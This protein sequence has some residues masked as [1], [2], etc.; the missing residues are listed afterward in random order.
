M[1]FVT[2]LTI[3]YRVVSAKKQLTIYRFINDIFPLAV[4]H[5]YSG[6]GVYGKCTYFSLEDR[7]HKNFD[8]ARFSLN[9][10]YKASPQNPLSITPTQLDGLDDGDLMTVVED[11]FL[12]MPY[13]KEFDASLLTKKAK[14][15]GYDS[16]IITG[17]QHLEGGKQLLALKDFPLEVITLN[18]SFIDKK[19]RDAVY[20]ELGQD[21]VTRKSSDHW[22]IMAIPPRLIKKLDTVL[23][24]IKSKD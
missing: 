23:R 12:N 13:G 6:D 24:K 19:D 1:S 18:I 17:S 22:D 7:T 5:L 3:K 10:K 21:L 11:G 2:A 14:K 20:R 9:F 8:A 15:M 4:T 16:I